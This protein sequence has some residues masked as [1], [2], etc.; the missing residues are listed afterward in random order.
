MAIHNKELRA[1]L[2]HQLS[3]NSK[4][5]ERAIVVLYQRQTT[6]EQTNSATVYQ[7]GQGFCAYAARRGTYYA[8]YVL[9]GG[10]L[11]GVHLDR[12]RN[13]AVKHVRQLVEMAEK[14]QHVQKK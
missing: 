14:K 7:N 11:T 10:R 4:L 5:V 12:A 13:I 3:I 2:I 9:S 6:D 8:K 1:S